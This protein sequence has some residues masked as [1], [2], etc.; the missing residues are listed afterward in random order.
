MACSHLFTPHQDE[1][2]S[3]AVGKE[4]PSF[5]RR[6]SQKRA[7]TIGARRPWGW[8]ASGAINSSWQGRR[9]QDT[10]CPW[11]RIRFETPCNFRFLH[12]S[13]CLVLYGDDVMGIKD[14]ACLH[15]LI[16]R[17]ENQFSC[18]LRDLTGLFGVGHSLVNGLF[19]SVELHGFCI[20]LL[21]LFLGFGI[22][23]FICGTAFLTLFR[24]RRG[25]LKGN[26]PAAQLGRIQL[27]ALHKV[28][29]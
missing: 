25:F 17:I 21:V 2:L 7:P 13:L 12:I 6:N 24:L 4:I 5:Q 8:S 16:C 28:V 15:S 9:W 18:I 10:H 22:A 23:C 1:T 11:N 26:G 27:G 3:A 19:S 29:A 20:A 14:T